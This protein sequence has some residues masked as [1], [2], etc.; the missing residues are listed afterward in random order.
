MSV[1]FAAIFFGT[2]ALTLAWWFWA[3][4]LVRGAAGESPR[5]AGRR[6]RSAR[7]ILASFTLL[8]F[9]GF[10]W[11]LV[12]RF[13]PESLQMAGLGRVPEP[14]LM[15][16]LMLWSIVV[17]PLVV[18]P[19]MTLWAICG[20]SAV[21]GRR[22]SR[23]VRRNR[24]NRKPIST[25]A[26]LKDG[27]FAAIENEPKWTR[28]RLLTNSLATAPVWAT[29]GLTGAGMLQRRR[30]RIRELTIEVPLLP[31]TLD[32]I[33]IAH[34]SDTHVGKFTRGEILNRIS[35][36]TNDLAAD[37]VLMTGDLI[38]HTLHDLP[39]AVRMV[40]RIDRRS[41]LFLIEGNHDL[42]DGREAFARGMTQAGLPL[43]RNETALVQVHGNAVQILGLEWHGRGGSVAE[44]VDAVARQRDR[45]A[46]PILLAHHPHAFD[47]AVELG[48][49]LT[50][51]GH[52][53][54]GQ[55]MA[56]SDF[57]A[58]PA[59]F[60]YWS[61]LYERGPS[62]LVVSN[63]AGNWFPLRTNAPAEIVRITLRAVT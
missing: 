33:T 45:S 46:F 10:A 55:L 49:P 29:L 3:D 36:A 59:M 34:V 47:R 40:D 41:G 51:A 5:D 43:L 19:S 28:R 31:K 61:G 15:G 20:L 35:D 21:L 14:W 39:E 11:L 25:S 23:A 17:L 57:G 24:T 53:H 60:K 12:G 58:G 42:F 13:W 9:M 52:T 18:I 6:W 62:R 4:K 22:I 38:D 2:P 27:V 16:L 7:S 32:G 1:L 44:Q 30:F 54:G 63:G 8:F 26:D 48:F 56:T 50:L 37:L